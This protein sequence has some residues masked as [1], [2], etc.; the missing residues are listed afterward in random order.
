MSSQVYTIVDV[1]FIDFFATQLPKL[2]WDWEDDLNFQ[3]LI[4]MIIT[5]T[6]C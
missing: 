2:F 3:Q 5:L 1:W 6:K 4:T